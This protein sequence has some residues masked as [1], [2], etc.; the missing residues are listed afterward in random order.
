M[1]LED[2]NIYKISLD[3]GERIWKV[4]E[5]W[6]SFEKFSMGKQLVTSADSIAANI[7]EGFGRYHYKDAKIFY[8]YARGSLFETK[9]WIIKTK[10]R[11]LI[12]E[13]SADEIL[14]LLNDLGI[15]LNNFIKTTGQ[16][17]MNVH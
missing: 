1:K 6:N 11:N 12:S 16:K 5:T 14:E 13:E 3:L 8:Y 9:T 4:V 15:R 10:N 7:A 17:S 2:L